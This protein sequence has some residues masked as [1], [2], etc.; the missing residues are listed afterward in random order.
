MDIRPILG[1]LICPEIVHSI[2]LSSLWYDLDGHF[3][4]LHLVCLLE[5]HIHQGI[6]VY[7]WGLGHGWSIF[8]ISFMWELTSLKS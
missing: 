4:M 1:K 5:A 7:S 3:N 2:L 8:C 6:I